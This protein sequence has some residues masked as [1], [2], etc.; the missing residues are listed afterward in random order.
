MPTE[1]VPSVADP[2]GLELRQ[3][4]R[5]RLLDAMAAAD[6][7]VLVLGRVANIRYVSG[8]PILWNA[9]HPPVRARVRGGAATPAR[10]TC[11]ARGTKGC[12]TTSPTTTSSGSPGTR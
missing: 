4:R 3:G 6:L 10:S 2:D 7:D 1:T 12:P 9:G 8:V 11:S 5:A